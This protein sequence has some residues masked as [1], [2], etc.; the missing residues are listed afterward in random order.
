MSKKS[1][2]LDNPCEIFKGF[3]DV[4]II[5]KKAISIISKYHIINHN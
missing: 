5:T 3:A 2:D 4:K 1:N